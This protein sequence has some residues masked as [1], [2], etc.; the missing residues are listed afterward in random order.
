MIYFNWMKYQLNLNRLAK[1]T[2]QVGILTV[3]A[4]IVHGI[5]DRGDPVSIISTV[6][7]GLIAIIASTVEKK[8]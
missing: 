7:V 6:I 5:I 8:P 4:G 2:C 3:A 1:A